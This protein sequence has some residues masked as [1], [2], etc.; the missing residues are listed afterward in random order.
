LTDLHFT[1]KKDSTALAIQSTSQV[2][3]SL[4]NNVNITYVNGKLGVIPAPPPPPVG[5]AIPTVRGVAGKTVSVPVNVTRMNNIG[6]I[7]LKVTYDPTKLTFMSVANFP[8]STPI[9]NAANGVLSFAWFGTTYL[10]IGTGKLMNLV[11]AY[12]GG[13]SVVGFNSAQSQVTD[14]VGNN[15]TLTFTNGVVNQD[16]LPHFTAVGAKTVAQNDT[17]SFAVLATDADAGDTL[18]Y[19]SGVLPTGAVFNPVS[20][21]F[22]WRPGYS[23]TPQVYNVWF[24]VTD[25]VGGMDSTQVAIT[26]T[27]TN[28]PPKFQTVLKDTLINQGTTLTFTYV[29]TDPD[30]GQTLTYSLVNPPSGASVTSA[31]VFT[32]TPPS[33]PARTYSVVAAVSDGSLTD[34]TRATI[35]VNRKPA[36][37]AIPAK[38][39]A[40]NDTLSFTVVATDPDT[41]DV[42]TYTSS[43]LPIGAVFNPVSKLFGWRP[44]FSIT[45]QT[46]NVWFYV[47]DPRGLKDSVQVAITVSKT[48]RPPKFQTVLKD[49][50]IN[51]GSSLSFKYVAID[52]DAGD[53]VLY[54]LANPPTGAA[55]TTAGVLTFTV[56]ASPAASYTITAVATDG[57]LTDTTRAKVSVNRKPVKVSQVPATAPAT[58]SRG[59]AFTFTVIA[60]DPDG[61][62]ITYTWKV[63]DSQVKTGLDSNYTT[64]FTDPHGTVKKVVCV[65]ADPT[66]LKDSVVWSFTVTGVQNPDGVPTTFA[67]GQNYPNPFNPSTTIRF[68]LPKEAP[69]TMEIYNILG[70]RVRTLLKGEGVNAGYHQVVW[71]GRDDY[72]NVVPSGV[73]LYHLSAGDFQ[74]SKKMT[75]LK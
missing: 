30:T 22:G 67:L 25:P 14:S 46:F 73:Y 1:L 34:T 53:V 9:T 39:V 71:D 58:I 13:S 37:T 63:N 48:D 4:G 75:L 66:G 33:N 8:G 35:T 70:I 2:T 52:P 41:A 40:Q 21:L 60:K 44:S 6:S 10:N 15:L 64:T 57:S 31:G 3:D 32:F 11:F 36:F 50:T 24:Y 54:S 38:T 19:S 29:A 20:K 72:G 55:I 23:I 16:S 74:A 56:P 68:D 62:A 5:L 51:E 45:P 49:T 69:V 61:G 7:S 17:L 47:V 43:V 59:V 42:L 28:R 26:V 27:K 18:T 65:F 12:T